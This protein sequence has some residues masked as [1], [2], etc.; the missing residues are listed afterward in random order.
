MWYRRSEQ[1]TTYVKKAQDCTQLLLPCVDAFVV[2][3]VKMPVCTFPD[4]RLD[5]A[6]NSGPTRYYQ[7]KRTNQTNA[8]PQVLEMFTETAQIVHG[9][10]RVARSGT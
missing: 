4:R 6:H 10:Q 3:H 5:V 9:R 7:R 2:G 8:P 1:G